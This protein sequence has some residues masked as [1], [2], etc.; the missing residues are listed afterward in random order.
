MSSTLLK[1]IL[2][3]DDEPNIRA[4]LPALL[5]KHGYAVHVEASVAAA[6]QFI[7]N[8]PLDILVCDLNIEKQGD[9]YKVIWALR[10]IN[11]RC[12]I[13]VLTAYPSLETAVEAIDQ[14]IDKYMIKPAGAHA[15][16][17]AI[18]ENP[19]AADSKGRILS[20]SYDVPL[21]QTRHMLF[22]H[23]GYDVVSAPNL[24]TALDQCEKNQFDVLILGHSIPVSDRDKII[25][26]FREYSSAPIISLRRTAVEQMPEN[27][28]YH[29]DSDPGTLLALMAQV[30][31]S[32]TTSK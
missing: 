15:I 31:E 12:K 26:K 5:R 24:Q 21:L 14:R 13:I 23:K 10:N 17:K 32:A 8:H 27:V 18:A 19:A 11:P 22:E 16:V 2:F 3:V 9:G 6:I 4:T 1:Q 29:I 30:L 28:D 7:Q 20:T 25:R